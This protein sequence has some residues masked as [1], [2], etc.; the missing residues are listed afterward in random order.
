[1][2]G[3]Q[4]GFGGD[5][6]PDNVFSGENMHFQGKSSVKEGHIFAMFYL[7][8]HPKIR[9]F[10]PKYT[11]W[12]WRVNMDGKGYTYRRTQISPEQ[13]IACLVLRT[14]AHRCPGGPLRYRDR[15]DRPD[16]TYDAMRCDVEV[17]VVTVHVYSL[18]IAFRR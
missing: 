7:T 15:I 16:A 8:T 9:D 13:E 10:V 1:M 12:M 5:G 6:N 3:L 4:C 18:A 2:R 14:V 11:L 17:A